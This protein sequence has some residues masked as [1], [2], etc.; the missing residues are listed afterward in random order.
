F[1]QLARHHVGGAYLLKTEF[2]VSV[3][4]TSDGRDG[5]GLGQD[6][7]NE[8]HGVS[9]H[10]SASCDEESPMVPNQTA[11][12]PPH[13][14]QPLNPWGVS[15]GLSVESGHR[16]S[17]ASDPRT[18]TR[19]ACWGQSRPGTPRGPGCGCSALRQ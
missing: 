17:A 14:R 11:R 7:V 8:L 2:W 15:E 1:G 19:C 13:R 6:G 9:R 3:Y 5:S 10:T 16:Q 12:L 4:V 18:W